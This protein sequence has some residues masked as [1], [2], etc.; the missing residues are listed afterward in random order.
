MLYLQYVES[1][2][3]IFDERLIQKLMKIGFQVEMVGKVINPLCFPTAALSRVASIVIIIS[4]VC[5]YHSQPHASF[6]MLSKI[7][8]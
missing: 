6:S 3:F 7:H 4:F 2:A 8:V 1:W 5:V